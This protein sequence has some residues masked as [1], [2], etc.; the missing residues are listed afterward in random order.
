MYG[1]PHIHISNSHITELSNQKAGIASL[2]VVDLKQRRKILLLTSGQPEAN[3]ARSG[4]GT[5]NER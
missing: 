3:V 1:A 2:S 5:G 4:D